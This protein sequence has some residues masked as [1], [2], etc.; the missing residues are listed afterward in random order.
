MLKSLALVTCRDLPVPDPDGA[1]LLDAVRALGARARWAAWDDPAV[2]WESFDSAVVRSTWNYIHHLEAFQSWA[3]RAA[4]VTKLLNPLSVLLWNSDKGYLRDLEKRGIP[5]VP[6]AY[7]PRE[8]FRP[9][10][11]L[12]A[13]RRWEE[14]VIK[15]QVG[16]GSFSTRRFP[17]K[18]RA[19]AERFLRALSAERDVLI[20]PYV[21]SVDGYG[22]RS[23]IW[24]D[25]QLTHAVRKSPRFDGRDE[26]AALVT[27]ARDERL[28]AEKVLEPL[29]KEL[30]YARVDVARGDDGGLLIMELELI[31]P[32]LFLYHE[33]RA[34]ARL[35]RACVRSGLMS[36]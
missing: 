33:P 13:S 30:L 15:P 28:F 5:V 8:G 2:D 7:V 21:A 24:I 19:E 35:A 34:L 12:L 17:L 27:I 9:L 1:P 3:R 29:A 6:T 22:E 11:E 18:E 25:G 31:E 16:A 26:A 10:A 20:Q 23:L 14:I 4:A 36:R 32:L